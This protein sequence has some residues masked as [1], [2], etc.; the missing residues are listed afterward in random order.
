[1]LGKTASRMKFLGAYTCFI[2]ILN[3]W[4]GA[5]RESRFYHVDNVVVRLLGLAFII[6][7]TALLLRQRGSLAPLAVVYGLSVME[8]VATKAPVFVLVFAAVF[9]GVPLAYILSCINGR[10]A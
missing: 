3:V 4:G 1:M 2:G 8:V 5:A 7:G 10:V 6:L 9:F